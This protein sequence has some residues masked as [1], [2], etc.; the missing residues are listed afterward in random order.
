[1]DS[2]LIEIIRGNL[3]KR[4]KQS[5]SQVIYYSLKTLI[6]NGSIP[7]GQRIN[8]Q[9]LA[10]SLSVSRTPIRKAI[11]L[12]VSEYLLEY[13]E[14]RGVLVTNI[15]ESTIEEIFDIQLRLEAMMYKEAMLKMTNEQLSNLIS[16]FNLLRNFNYQHIPSDIQAVI[17]RIKQLI[18]SYANTPLLSQMLNTLAEHKE[19]LMRLLDVESQT[20]HKQRQILLSEHIIILSSL[21][22][23]EAEALERTLN[24]HIQNS[25]Q[26][27][28]ALYWQDFS[29]INSE[30]HTQEVFA[31]EEVNCPLYASFQLLM[32]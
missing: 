18:L 13:V 5:K 32:T 31:C 14:N 1:M 20:P 4:V 21:L 9:Q 23:N 28:L 27:V 30:E 6:L 10:Q 3:D 22:R 26:L 19:I 8:E 29:N 25:K 24:Q 17:N 12:L 2:K 11:D 7:M 16:H 15:N